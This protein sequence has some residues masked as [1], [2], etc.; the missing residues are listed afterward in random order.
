MSLTHGSDIT[1]EEIERV[2]SREFTPTRFA[3]LCNSLVFALSGQS[4]PGLPSFTELTNVK[5]GGIDAE[6]EAD[7]PAGVPSNSSLLREGWNVYQYKQRDIFAS[8]REKTFT[9]LKSGVK[10]A[11]KEVCDRTKK[12]PKLYALF[13]NLHLTHETKAKKGAHAQKKE[14]R[15]AILYGYDE[16]DQVDVQIV[17]AAELAT[18][19]NNVPLLRSAFF[20]SSQFISW[21]DF[22]NQQ[23]LLKGHLLGPWIAL[24]GRDSELKDIKAAIDDTDVRGIVLYGPYDIGKSRLVIETTQHR[25]HEVIVA[26]DA[27]SVRPGDLMKLQSLSKESIVV[28]DDPD[29]DDAAAFVN[30]ALKTTNIK[31]V[32]T[33]PQAEKTPAPNLGQDTRIRSF[34]LKALLP[35]QAE[36]LL[37]KANSH[38]DHSLE[39][40][41]LEQ[42]GGNP[43]VILL[44]GRIGR[45]LRQSASS[46]RQEVGA[47]FSERIGAN[48]GTEYVNVLG[49]CSIMRAVGVFNEPQAEIRTICKLF[50][51]GIDVNKVVTS[52]PKLA[53][54]GLVQKRGSY[55][56]VTPRIL[57][58][59]LASQTIAGRSAELF[60]LVSG[61]SSRPIARLFD[62]LHSVESDDV[63]LLWERI[64]GNGGLFDTLDK[65]VELGDLLRLVAARKPAK[66]AAKLDIQIA[67]ADVAKL[68]AIEGDAR[69]DLMWSIDQMLFREESAEAAIRILKSLALAEVETYSNNATGVF[70]ES[71]MYWHPQLSIPLGRRIAILRDMVAADSDENS[72]ALGLRAIVT[73][74]TSQSGLS[75]RPSTS[76]IP[77]SS[78]PELTYREVWH[79]NEALIDLLIALAENPNTRVA[80]EAS[81]HLPSAL[82]Q[83]S[84]RA[85]LT[86][87]VKR[88]QKIMALWQNGKIDISASE[89]ATSIDLIKKDLEVAVLVPHIGEEK[90]K[91]E[92]ALSDAHNLLEFIENGEYSYRVKRW[93]GGWSH[94][95]EQFTLDDGTTLFPGEK[96]IRDLVVELIGNP[97]LL[98]DDL[99]AWLLTDKARQSYAFFGWLGRLDIESAFLLRI[100]KEAGSTLGIEALQ[101]YFWGW[102]NRSRDEAE[103]YLDDV[104]QQG[105]FNSLFY[106]NATHALGGSRKGA[107]RIT[108][109]I[110]S[111]ALDPILA[112]R[113][114]VTGGWSSTLDPSDF[115]KLLQAVGGVDLANANAALDFYNMWLFQKRPVIPELAEYIWTCLETCPTVNLNDAYD[116]DVV[117]KSL[118]SLDTERAFR[119]LEKLLAQPYEKHSWNPLESAKDNGFFKSLK[120]LDRKRV[121]SIVLNI[122]LNEKDR[123]GI[124]HSVSRAIDL[125]ED[126]SALT[127]FARLSK[128]N[129]MVVIELTNAEQP[130]FWEFGEEII[131]HYP[132][133]E[134]IESALIES[135]DPWKSGGFS[136][137]YAGHLE[138]RRATAE[139]RIPLATGPAK[140]WLAKVENKFRELVPKALA[141]EMDEDINGF[142][143]HHQNELG[144]LRSWA[145]EA[146][147]KDKKFDL[148]KKVLTPSDILRALPSLS[149][150]K[151]EIEELKRAL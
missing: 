66:V 8:G 113:V 62:R 6:W 58:D 40:W 126:G 133:D 112:E 72:L 51:G 81:S 36:K 148:L 61:L 68:K 143:R 85:R 125:P 75:F 76:S 115:L 73:G 150:S 140:D 141:S 129:A 13:T 136:G 60:A 26:M 91:F 84:K 90:P 121:W 107:E 49:M 17:S 105:K 135:V 127:D 24:I 1:A 80:K 111:G 46:F 48:M 92:T 11:F 124:E 53:K 86:E 32:L 138:D 130:G 103:A 35:E 145:V 2:V 33:I 128:Q 54:A 39:S 10:G 43:G 38:L 139:S 12:R 57:A 59:Y 78:R 27:S 120:M 119:L 69:R 142:R 16:P 82:R 149:L 131:R 47:R 7:F 77:L 9:K 95:S 74:L 118:I 99:L 37:K 28:V 144:E 132:C 4:P 44:A 55:V 146:L 114:L 89:F 87:L 20:A 23:V 50:G 151:N 30:A 5:D 102:A 22:Q 71:F 94:S 15:N 123:H 21:Q 97:D 3:S 109:L 70:C 134:D 117:A 104:H 29:L 41:I 98:E 65:A 96:E 18:F 14:L 83:G 108:R 93:I 79:Y 137:S 100:E 19:L 101:N 106:L 45:N 122:L 31:V 67:S 147:I 52:I 64:L 42:A 63:E 88:A 116:M 110:Q 25:F 56:E 34:E